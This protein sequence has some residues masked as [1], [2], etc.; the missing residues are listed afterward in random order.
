MS[1]GRTK[2][3]EKEK[4][5]LEA[6]RLGERQDSRKGRFKESEHRQIS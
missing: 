1:F 5:G 2:G 6:R 4:L 3:R